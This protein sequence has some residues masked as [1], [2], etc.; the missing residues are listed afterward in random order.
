MKTE[1]SKNIIYIEKSIFPSK[2][3]R[4]YQ[5]KLE[6]FKESWIYPKK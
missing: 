3:N 2:K 4:K 1:I 6:I 5:R